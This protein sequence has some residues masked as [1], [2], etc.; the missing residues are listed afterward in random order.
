MSYLPQSRKTVMLEATLSSAQTASQ[1]DIVLFD[2]LRATSTHGVS[3]NAS[4]GEITLS[5]AKDYYVQ[6]SIDVERS[7]TTS[8]WRFV[9]VDSTGSE[10]DAD[11]GGFDAQWDYHTASNSAGVPN[12]TYTAVYQVS[13]PSIAVSPIRL[14][15]TSLAAN[16][17]ILLSTAVLIVEVSR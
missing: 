17:S 16:S 9:W 13:A 8:S 4:T 2:T 3:L 10:I 11:S 15:A 1:G 12:A 7:S 14:K 5:N 6:A